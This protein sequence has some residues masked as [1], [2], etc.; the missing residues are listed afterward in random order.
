MMKHVSGK[1]ERRILDSASVFFYRENNS[2]IEIFLARRNPQLRSFPGLWS[3]IGGKVS[4]DDKK[5]VGQDSTGLTMDVLKACAFRE[6]IEEIGLILVHPQ[7][8]QIEPA[9]DYDWNGL[10]PAGFK[11][12]PEFTIVNPIFK[13]QYFL[14]KLNNGISFNLSEHHKE[15]VEWAWKTPI[16]WIEAFENQQIRIPP[17]VL[18]L[19]RTFI[20][21]K[22]PQEAAALSEERNNKPI[23]LQTPIEIHPGVYV[24]PIKSQT[25]LPATTTNCFI[26][27]DTEHRYIIDPG[28]HLEEE[29]NRLLQTIDGLTDGKGLKGILLTHH[30]RDHWQSISY[31][32]KTL[33]VPVLAHQ[34]TKELLT[35]A[36]TEFTV[37]KTLQDGDVLNLGFDTKK[38]PWKLEVLFTGGHS[39]DHVAYLDQRFNALIAGDMVAGIGTVLVEDMGEY[40]TSLDRLITKNIG[41]LLPGHGTINYE[42]E[43]LLKQYREHRIQRLNL[44]LEAFSKHANVATV[45]ELTEHAY[46]DVEKEYHDVAKMQVQTYLQY[47]EEKKQVEKEGNKFRKV[48]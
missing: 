10:I 12:T 47:L 44:I 35:S 45:E 8:K 5:F 16:E 26:I 15:F 41:V 14:Y 33:Q 18:S 43:K 6:V 27:G 23:G 21:D 9:E 7:V 24:I 4:S 25:I 38:R 42:G 31:L 13:T 40:L 32:Q 17:P 34:K 28:S 22:T 39:K 1:L 11:Q 37:D 36:T 29:N 48:N 19:L 2:K 3:G 20:P 30:H 46:S